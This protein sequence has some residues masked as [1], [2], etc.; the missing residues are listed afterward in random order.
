ML[1]VDV[2][3]C[4]NGHALIAFFVRQVLAT[5]EED[6]IWIAD[7]N[8]CT[9][10]FLFGIAAPQGTLFIRQHQNLPRHATDDFCLVGQSDSGIV[11]EQ[12]IILSADDGQLLNARRVFA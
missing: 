9:L 12:N 4:E 10:K 8:F 6:D 3:P 7:R 5:V 1:A 2:F 11:F